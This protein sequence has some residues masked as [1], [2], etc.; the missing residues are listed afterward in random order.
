MV[1]RGRA[2]HHRSVLGVID[3]TKEGRSSESDG[4]GT[5]RMAVTDPFPCA[6]GKITF[7]TKNE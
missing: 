2:R 7:A 3:R 1:L 5:N 4:R 6:N